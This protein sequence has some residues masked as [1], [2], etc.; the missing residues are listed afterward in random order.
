MITTCYQSFCEDRNLVSLPLPQEATLPPALTY[1]HTSSTRDA[2][3][4]KQQKEI[5]KIMSY[6]TRSEA[7]KIQI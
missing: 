7:N 5:L 4:L 6:L 2:I 1:R 3:L